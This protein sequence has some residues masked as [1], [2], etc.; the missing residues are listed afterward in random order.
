MT[1]EKA[2]RTLIWKHPDHIPN[3]AHALDLMFC[4]LGTGMEWRD[5]E[6]VDAIE[7]NYL[8]KKKS[9]PYHSVRSELRKMRKRLGRTWLNSWSHEYVREEVRAHNAKVREV[10]K[11]IDE[12]CRDTTLAC[13]CPLSGPGGCSH[14]EQVPDD[15]RPDWL[16]G[17]IETLV[18][19]EN[20]D[21][22]VEKCGH[23]NAT[24]IQAARKI[25]RDL[26]RR[27]PAAFKEVDDATD[28]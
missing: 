7:D 15:V 4:V 26:K 23:K 20:T 11:H 6:I 16:G 28:P 14:L 9:K 17:V 24:N 13:F 1:L 2:I 12:A 8:N 10:H 22:A 25:R 5:G 21:P 18:L 3:R 27:F 19:I